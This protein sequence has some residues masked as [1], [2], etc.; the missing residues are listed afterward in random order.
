MLNPQTEK[1]SIRDYMKFFNSCEIAAKRM[2]S[3]DQQYLRDIGKLAPHHKINAAQFF[4]LYGRYPQRI[5]KRINL[6]QNVS[7]VA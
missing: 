5:E 3:R 1:V 4:D 6:Y 7:A 2:K